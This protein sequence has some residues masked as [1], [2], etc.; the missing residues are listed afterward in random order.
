MPN[1]IHCSVFNKDH[2]DEMRKTVNESK[3][4]EEL[5]YLNW[6]WLKGYKILKSKSLTAESWNQKVW[7]KDS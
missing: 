4:V 2:D 1:L 7:N 3:G 6:N 5:S